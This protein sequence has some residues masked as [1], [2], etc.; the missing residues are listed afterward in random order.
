MGC[1]LRDIYV[2]VRVS[3]YADRPV[4]WNFTAAEYVEVAQ[5]WR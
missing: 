5:G 1:R 4:K 3:G 2:A